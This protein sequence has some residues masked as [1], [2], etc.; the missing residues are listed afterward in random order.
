MP[1]TV[2]KTIYVYDDEGTFVSAA[3]N[4]FDSE[5]EAAVS[6]IDALIEWT[7]DD[8]H[9]LYDDEQ[10]QAH[11]AELEALKVNIR[12]VE[13]DLSSSPWFESLLGFTFSFTEEESE[14]KCG[15]YTDDAVLPNE[16]H[17]C[18]LCGSNMNEAGECLYAHNT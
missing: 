17:C 8:G 5:Q 16:N 3:V 4:E 2:F 12:G 11:L 1:E 9:A 6:V 10:C 13:V 15:Q 18:S 7:N 14:R